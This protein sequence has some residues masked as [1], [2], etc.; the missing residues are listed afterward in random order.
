MNKK[1]IAASVLTFLL[2]T[3]VVMLAFNPGPQPN[4]VTGLSIGDLIDIVFSI[5]WPI[6]IAFFIVMFVLAGFQ[7]LTARGNPEQVAQARQ[8]VIWGLVGVAVALLA[9]SIPFVIKNMIPG[10]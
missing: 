7:F 3:P 8:F 2:A 5:L 6:A 1:L 10:L 9:W 4:T